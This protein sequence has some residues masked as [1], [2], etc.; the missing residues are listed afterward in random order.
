MPKCIKNEAIPRRSQF[1]RVHEKTA[2]ANYETAQHRAN[3]AREIQ[4]FSLM[5]YTGRVDAPFFFLLR[6]S[7]LPEISGVN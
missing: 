7:S 5:G 6:A 1:H 2:E 4:N 3:S